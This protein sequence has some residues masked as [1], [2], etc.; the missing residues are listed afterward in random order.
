[1][2]SAFAVLNETVPAPGW[3]LVATTALFAAAVSA[4]SFALMTTGRRLLLNR[5]NV[6]GT[7]FHE[8]GH[9]LVSIL[10]GGGV[11]RIEITGAESGS[12]R[13]WNPSPFAGVLAT[14]AGY[15]MPPLAGL[16]AAALLHRG[17]VPAVLA[18][19]AVAM[20]F[21][22][23][24]TRDVITGLVVVTVG[25]VVFFALRW[26]PDWV[27]NGV[28]Y[29]E[30]WLLLTSEVG[31]L[32]AL[33]AN[34]VRGVRGDDASSLAE[35]TGVPGG[36]WIVAWFVLIGWAVWCAFPMLWP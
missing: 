14:A 28:A 19:T 33:V 2:A 13:H 10:T 26:A 6:L 34:R 8:G 16:G 3:T 31:G 35:R 11:F 21:I 24:F 15:A 9:A 30:A 29:A 22:L 7:L 23:L 36:V 4:T 5:V 1:M 32:G 20:L 25:A 12:T 27:K 17:L 18:L